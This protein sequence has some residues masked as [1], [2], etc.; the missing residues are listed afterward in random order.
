[1]TQAELAKLANVSPATVSK[2]FRYS[3][4]INKETREHIFRIAKEHHCFE[5]FNKGIYPQAVI[6]VICPESSSEWYHRM[7][8]YLDSMI[9]EMGAVMT[10]SLSHFD[11]KKEET[12]F[13]YYTYYQKVNGVI[14]IDS[15]SVLPNPFHIPVVLID[16]KHDGKFDSVCT[17]FQSGINEAIAYFKEM[18][19]THIGFIGERF[20]TQKQECFINAMK[21]HD[22][23]L[24]DEYIVTSNA[25]FEEAGYQC[26]KTLLQ[27]SKPLPTAILAAYDYIAAGA[28]RYARYHS[29]AVPQDISFIGI[30]DVKV[31]KH[32]D[33]TSLQT[34]TKEKCKLAIELI[35][36][37]MDNKY[38]VER[39][40]I[41]LDCTLVKR[42]SVR[43]LNFEE[44]NV[45]Y[46]PSITI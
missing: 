35:Q 27:S 8:T 41:I 25:R 12:L 20:T 1:M 26:M 34:Y 33:L 19:H 22:L 38:Y 21:K 2:A 18:G 6:A 4:N 46:I 36:K 39:E 44:E 32:I 45:Q 43:N 40:K 13:S 31:A 3:D 30:D 42:N 28:M 37:K 10:L 23:P 5:K 14:I 9:I 7:I 24:I 16:S 29:L 15:Q 11:P 17:E